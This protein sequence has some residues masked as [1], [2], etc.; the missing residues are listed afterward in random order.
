MKSTRRGFAAKVLGGLAAVCCT[1]FLAQAKPRRVLRPEMFLDERM[2]FGEKNEDRVCHELRLTEGRRIRVIRQSGNRY[3]RSL[4]D[5]V[6]KE[7]RKAMT[8]R[9]Q[10]VSTVI[11]CTGGKTKFSVECDEGGDITF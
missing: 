6:C 3:H 9:G 2:S 1:P 10:R 4:T 5:Y 11:D 8:Q 7:V